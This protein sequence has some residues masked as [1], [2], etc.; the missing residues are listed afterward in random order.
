MVIHEPPLHET[1]SH[2]N[3]KLTD[4]SAIKTSIEKVI[5]MEVNYLNEYKFTR[6]LGVLPDALLTTASYLYYLVR[7]MIDFYTERLINSVPLS[8][9]NETPKC[10]QRTMS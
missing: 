8:A 1:T 9:V 6:D 10:A 5:E 7:L 4:W 2:E 3:Y